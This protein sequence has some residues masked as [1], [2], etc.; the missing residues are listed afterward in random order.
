MIYSFKKIVMWRRLDGNG[1]DM[2]TLVGLKL[3]LVFLVTLFLLDN[4]LKWMLVYRM[5]KNILCCSIC[6]V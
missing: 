4:H 2:Y 5:N 3:L 1:P 6:S